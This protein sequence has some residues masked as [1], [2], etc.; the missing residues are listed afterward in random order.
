MHVTKAKCYVKGKLG[1]SVDG[2]ECPTAEAGPSHYVPVWTA[3]PFPSQFDRRELAIKEEDKIKYNVSAVFAAMRT[4][5]I[6]T[7]PLWGEDWRMIR[8]VGGIYDFPFHEERHIQLSKVFLD[9]SSGYQIRVSVP[10]NVLDP[11]NKEMLKG[12]AEFRDGRDIQ[13]G[14]PASAFNITE[15]KPR[16]GDTGAIVIPL[17]FE[18][19][20]NDVAFETWTFNLRKK[21]L[22][23]SRMS[24]CMKTLYGQDIPSMFVE[25]TCLGLR[26]NQVFN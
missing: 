17:T 5:V 15:A 3:D 25:C 21:W 9:G 23:Y 13:F 6:D 4:A 11:S 12:Q 7:H 18:L 1:V 8:I 10:A 16:R 22:P 20:Y 26:S 2:Y 14:I 19:T 24:I